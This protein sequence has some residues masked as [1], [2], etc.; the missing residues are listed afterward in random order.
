MMSSKEG[1]TMPDRNLV[2]VS[3]VSAMLGAIMLIVTNILH[4]RGADFGDTAE[5]LQEVAD[6]G[7]YLG[8]HMGLLVGV[9]L[10]L[11]GL[12]GLSR[13]LADG[14]GAVWRVWDSPPPWRRARSWRWPSR[15]T[16][17]R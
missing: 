5:Q 7:I 16:A 9:L 2:R 12:V 4:P 17:S 15:W 8:D 13:S 14:G 3:S 10:L 11:G 1:P 6:S